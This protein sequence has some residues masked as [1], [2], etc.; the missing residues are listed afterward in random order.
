MLLALHRALLN[1]VDLFCENGGCTLDE[2]IR[3]TAFVW[4]MLG[5]TLGVLAFSREKKR[6]GDNLSAAAY[7]GTDGIARNTLERYPQRILVRFG[8]LMLMVT[9]LRLLSSLLRSLTASYSSDTVS[10][11]VAL[12]LIVH[13]LACD[14]DYANGKCNRGRDLKNLRQIFKGGTMSLNGALLSTTLLASR[15]S[16]DIHTFAFVSLS[17]IAFAF[18]PESRS[19]IARHA[20]S[21]LV[22]PNL[23]IT[24]ALCLAASMTLNNWEK[25]IFWYTL[26]LL[27]LLVPGVKFWLQRSKVVISGP[28]DIAKVFPNDNYD[29]ETSGS[30]NG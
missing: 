29:D 2:E 8:D 28:W 14:Y 3:H 26:L 21:S 22:S 13:L 9:L 15:L 16:S 11:L 12:G 30:K 27:C 18:Y 5:V 10:N 17:I 25:M 23:L 6:D 1:D 19:Y 20:P 4:I 7:S 24:S